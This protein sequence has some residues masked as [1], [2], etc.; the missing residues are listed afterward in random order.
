MIAHDAAI[1]ILLA[2]LQASTFGIQWLKPCS[3]DVRITNVLGPNRKL[4]GTH[5][6]VNDSVVG[7]LTDGEFGEDGHDYGPGCDEN[8][9]AGWRLKGG[10]PLTIAFSFCQPFQIDTF[11]VNVWV[12]SALRARPL[13]GINVT[14]FCEDS[15]SVVDR[16]S[17]DFP[18][19]RTDGNR[20]E[21][22][23]L[24]LEINNSVGCPSKGFVNLTLSASNPFLLLGEVAFQGLFTDNSSSDNNTSKD[25]TSDRPTN[26][27]SSP[28]DSENIGLAVGVGLGISLVLLALVV[29]II[30]MV[31]RR[32]YNTN[33]KLTPKTGNPLSDHSKQT[34]NGSSGSC[35]ETLLANPSYN[36]LPRYTCT[37]GTYHQHSESARNT[38]SETGLVGSYCMIGETGQP[39]P[40]T[41]SSSYDDVC[42]D[43]VDKKY[44]L[45]KA[46]SY[47]NIWPGDAT[48]QQERTSANYMNVENDGQH[49]KQLH[50]P[51]SYEDVVACSDP[52]H[53]NQ[54]TKTDSYE[55]VSPQYST[56]KKPQPL[57]KLES[58]QSATQGSHEFL[59][60]KSKDDN[61]KRTSNV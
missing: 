26:G 8:P 7:K 21:N 23:T 17:R 58:G 34:G 45:A 56:V 35:G 4:N 47:D 50:R 2:L 24:R 30:I 22:K 31:W 57:P 5:Y 12:V 46:A 14:L 39:K 59:Y 1:P 60:E 55:E 33:E 41:K 9:W 27:H 44:S 53:G 10:P 15:G 54:V 16:I 37:S 43:N 51:D 20:V 52:D 3:Y 38:G 32:C 19:G 49:M 61:S 29:V 36:S 48:E 28:S 42:D 11:I 25:G 6:C 18:S 40:L 13:T